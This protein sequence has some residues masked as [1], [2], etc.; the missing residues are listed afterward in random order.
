[1]SNNSI[2]GYENPKPFLEEDSHGQKSQDTLDYTPL[3]DMY[4]AFIDVLGF[5]K[6]FDDIKLTDDEGQVDKYRNVFNYYFE[7]MNAATFMNTDSGEQCYAGQTSD[8]LYFY[9][10]RPDFLLEFIKIFMHFNLYAM[11]KDVFF[12]GG[13]ARGKLFI[14]QKYQFYGDSVIRAYL[15]ESKVSH[16]P[17][18]TVDKKTYDAINGDLGCNDYVAKKNKRYYI[19]PF[20]SLSKKI[21]SVIDNEFTLKDVD[22]SE[23]I[24]NIENNKNKFEYDP[25][26]YMKYV[27]LEEEY[28][29]S[30][31]NIKCGDNNI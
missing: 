9:T 2:K 14:K 29:G 11:S 24:K 27:F 7:L 23:I 13:I 28:K 31:K 26:N 3:D 5:K 25:D 8:S 4:F 30:Q 16:Y 6:L 12:R 10:K 19:K 17:I 22:S 15:L 18:I 20:V 21:N 1:M